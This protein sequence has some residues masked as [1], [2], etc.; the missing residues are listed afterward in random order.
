MLRDNRVFLVL[1]ANLNSRQLRYALY[2]I[3]K[4]FVELVFCSKENKIIEVKSFDSGADLDKYIYL[5]KFKF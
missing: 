2:A 5:I 4:F 1:F 3:D